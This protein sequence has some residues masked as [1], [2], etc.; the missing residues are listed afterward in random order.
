MKKLAITFLIIIALSFSL[1]SV[2]SYATQSPVSSTLGR[3]STAKPFRANADTHLV[4]LPLVSKSSLSCSH[5]IG[6][7]VS[8]A[9]ALTNYADVR[10]GDMVCIA[11]G[12]RGDLLLRNFQGTAEDPITFINLRGQ[13][14]IHSGISHGIL[15]QNSRF[16]RLTGTGTDDIQYGLKVVT[17]TNVGID[18]GYKSS[19]FEIDHIEVSGVGGAGISAKTEAVCSDGSSNDYDYDGDGIKLGDPDDVV[20]RNN[21][22]QYNLAFH[23]NYIHDVGTEGIYVGSSFYVGQEA[24][25]NSGT[26]TI[27]AP[28]I[29]GV[30]IHNNKIT[31]TGWDGIQVGSATENCSIHYNEILRDSQ[32]NEPYQQSSIMNNPG[33]VCNIHSNFIQNGGGPGIFVQGNGGNIIYNNLIVNPGQNKPFGNNCGDGITV[34]DGSNPGNSIYILN[35]TVVTPKNFGINFASDKGADNRIQNNIIVAPGSYYLCGEDAYIQVWRHTNVLTAN[36]LK[37][38]TLAEIK[39]IAPA[40]NNYAIRSDSPAVD[41]G[42]NWNLGVAPVDYAGISRPQGKSYDIGAYEFVP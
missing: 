40:S 11:A 22:T 37:S 26:E 14:V 17:S 32:A 2:S 7:T 38:T 21:F 19:D 3:M 18:I 13:V 34:I 6:Q 29:E 10:P 25:C 36:N 4:F 8:V 27:Y 9:D 1:T 12:L 33:S 30:S 42:I 39:F 20:N 15:V 31:D 24:R 41:S 35:N 23:D 28:I 5:I 16:F